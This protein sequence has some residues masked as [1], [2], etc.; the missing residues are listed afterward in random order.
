ML[1]FSEYYTDKDIMS[2]R[3]GAPIG[4]ALTPIINPANLRIEGW[5]ATE[6]RNKEEM[7]LPANE[8]R[9]IVAR[10]FIVNDH[11]AITHPDDLVRMDSLVRMR[12]QVIGK[13]VKTDQKRRLGKVSNYTVDDQSMM[14]Q[15]LYVSRGAVRGL[16]KQELVI[17]RNQIVE[18]NDKA[19]I[20]RDT[21]IR[22]G[23]GA[24]AIA[25]A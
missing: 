19:I 5:F 18:I 14:I 25:A 10:G 17:D 24:P 15:K 22:V 11:D 20:V 2:L 16:T 6:R 4:H 13:T 23:A 7:I 12:F 9:E 3:V 8:I 21:S 1:R